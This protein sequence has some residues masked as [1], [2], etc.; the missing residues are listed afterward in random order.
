M[1]IYA[2]VVLFED[3]DVRNIMMQSKF[4]LDARFSIIIFFLNFDLH[5]CG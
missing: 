1:Q 2:S 5:E 4:N 3:L